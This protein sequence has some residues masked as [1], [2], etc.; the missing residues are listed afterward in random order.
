MSVNGRVFVTSDDIRKIKEATIGVVCK[1]KCGG[2]GSIVSKNVIR[3]CECLLEFQAQLAYLCAGIPKKYWNFTF[4]DLLPAF[5]KS[6]TIALKIISN[7]FERIPEMIFDGVGLYIQGKSG[8]AKSALASLILKE[9]KLLTYDCYCIRMS[10][11]TKL[12]FESLNDPD[13]RDMLKWLKDDV[14]LLV[15][16]EIDK[17]YRIQSTDGFAGNQINEFFGDVYNSKKALIVTSNLSKKD[18]SKVH[19]LNVVDRLSELVDVVLVGESYRNQ[20]DALK[21]IIGE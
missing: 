16:D 12:V 6:N 10:Q 20:E 9:A 17:D 1:N 7:Y 11:L 19:A 15:I 18:L 21:K 3:D 5:Q 13:K 2:T 8:L 14:Q 4:D